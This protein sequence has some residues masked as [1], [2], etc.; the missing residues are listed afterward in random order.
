VAESERKTIH[1]EGQHDAKHS[2][3]SSSMPNATAQ[4]STPPAWRNLRSTYIYMQHDSAVCKGQHS[5]SIAHT[6]ARHSPV[7]HAASVAEPAATKCMH[8]DSTVSAVC[9]ASAWQ[10]SRMCCLSCVNR[11]H[12]AAQSST[13]PAWRNLHGKDGRIRTLER[14]CSSMQCAAHAQRQHS[15]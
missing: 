5:F 7:L 8:K 13:R 2:L 14:Q 9:T 4:S 15:V 6:A 10:T 1:A 3:H 12:C 11:K